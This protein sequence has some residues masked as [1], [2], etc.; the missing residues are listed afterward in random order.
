[1][2]LYGGR[3]AEHEVSI[4]SAR[5][6]AAHIDRSR[7][8]PVFVYFT[9]EGGWMPVFPD[10]DGLPPKKPAEGI[11]HSFLP[12]G[13]K[14]PFYLEADIYFPVL[15]GPYGEDGRLQSI[16]E[17]GGQPFV[18][19]SSL[20]SCLAMD[21]VAS[22]I[23]FSAS[24]LKTVGFIYFCMPENDYMLAEAEK[25]LS[26]PLFVKPA[27]LGSSVGISK[28]NRSSEL[29]P[30]MK[31]AFSHGDKIILEQA[32]KVREIEVAVM[33]NDDL[34]VSP[35]AEVFPANEFYD[36]EDK[37]VLGLTR[38]AL[39]ADLTPGQEKTVRA[40]AE[41]AFRSLF[42]RGMARVD[43]FID[44]DNGDILLN[45]VNTIPGFTDISMF[46]K[47]FSLLGID[48]QQLITRL[49]ELGFQAHD[50]ERRGLL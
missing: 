46:P 42:L 17:M 20:G 45:E 31:K 38:F 32:R 3:S 6:V 34:L 44:K 43:L 36:Y 48:F 12:W 14:K 10:A 11:V 13:N 16:L 1:M 7:Y 21:K 5:A 25:K 47:L 29:L 2:I 18:G 27:A 30:A 24:G 50:Q 8:E 49:I 28:V 37:Y 19:A 35:P 9:R 33:G 40:M 41:T 26:F 22:K 15:H 23:I 4:A 39:P